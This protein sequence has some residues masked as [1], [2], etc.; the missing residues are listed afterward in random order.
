MGGAGRGRAGSD[1]LAKGQGRTQLHWE[2]GAAG[3][4]GPGE[5]EAAGRE[6]ERR[7]G[8]LGKR[9]LKTGCGLTWGG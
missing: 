9:T 2:W 1:G 3:G 7:G 8:W 4:G 5:D 6:E